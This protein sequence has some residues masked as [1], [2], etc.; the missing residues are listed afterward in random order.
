MHS[1]KPQNIDMTPTQ[2]K[3]IIRKMAN[4]KAPGLDGI[5]G[6]WIKMFVSM[7]ERIALHLQSCITRDEVPD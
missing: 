6:Y 7:Q 3:E 1:S 5:H 2:I 4:W